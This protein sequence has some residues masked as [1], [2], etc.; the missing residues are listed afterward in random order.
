M[1]YVILIV[2]VIML[3]CSQVKNQNLQ[4][5]NQDST[6][7]N[8]NYNKLTPEEESVILNKGTERPFTGEYEDFFE[9]GTYICK[10]CNA[11]L[12][13][14]D[15]KF[16][17]G[18]GWPSF[19]DEIPGAVKKVKDSDGMRTE[20]ICNN[21]GAHLGH[22]FT[23]E[24]FTAKDTRHCVNSISLKFVRETQISETKCT[25]ICKSNNPDDSKLNKV[26]SSGNNLK[27]E[28]N[29]KSIGKKDTTG[30]NKEVKTEKA[31]FAGG[32]FWGV[33]YYFQKAKGVIST[34]VGYI[35]GHKDNPTYKEVCSGTTGH[36]EA[37]EVTFD[38]SQT[39]YE[40]L[41]KLF[42][43]IHDFT[44]TNGQGP[45]IGEQYL[46]EIFYLDDA[47]KETAEKLNKILKDKGYK[48]ATTL[49]KATT[50]W[51]AEDYHQE[52]YEHKGTTPYCHSWKKIF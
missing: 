38:P 35:G 33:E 21:C 23:G 46:S 22:V 39:S 41:T 26:L 36:V 3:G 7:Q 1:K 40:D 43:E 25:E 5:L 18:C 13:R 19:D 37:M 31:I 42:F 49:R 11:P 50:F 15:S 8:M 34:Q 12:Y 14:S 17:S 24:G 52:Y 28:Q 44:Q 2:A 48:V 51:N 9:K 27:T 47:Q 29:P 45:D 10:R 32:C 20:I 6:K 4:T 16:E 30:M